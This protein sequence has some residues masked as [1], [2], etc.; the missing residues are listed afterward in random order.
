MRAAENRNR[1]K[2]VLQERQRHEMDCGARAAADRAKRKDLTITAA[3]ANPSSALGDH[4][5]DCEFIFGKD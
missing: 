1:Q 2:G 3:G 5:F 4:T